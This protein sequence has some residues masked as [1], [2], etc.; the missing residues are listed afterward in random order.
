MTVEDKNKLS[1]REF[2][3]LA[4]AGAAFS[5]AP[6]FLKETPPPNQSSEKEW[7]QLVREKL[8][9]GEVKE[10]LS[11]VPE[12]N[13]DNDGNLESRGIR[14]PFAETQWSK[15]ERTTIEPDAITV[16]WTGD[17]DPEGKY[18]LGVISGYNSVRYRGSVEIVTS[19]HATIGVYPLEHNGPETQDTDYISILQTQRPENGQPTVSSHIR[20]VLVPENQAYDNRKHPINALGRMVELYDLPEDYCY[21]FDFLDNYNYEDANARTISLE[22]LGSNFD[23]EEGHPPAQLIANTVGV[24]LAYMEK[25]PDINFSNITGHHEIQMDKGDPG[26]LFMAELRLV[27]AL[28]ILEG[29]N[30]RLKDN[31]F[32]PFYKEGDTKEETIKRF[33]DFHW[34][35]VVN[36]RWS[37]PKEVYRW[38]KMTNYWNIYQSLFAK[39]AIPVADNFI[40]PVEEHD[41]KRVVLGNGFAIPEAHEG[42]DLNLQETRRIINEDLGENISSIANGRVVFADKVYGVPGLGNTVV[43][44][45]ITGGTKVLS[46]YAHLDEIKVDKGDIVEIGQNIATMGNSGGQMD[47]HLHFA[48]FPAATKRER[49]FNHY[50]QL[51]YQGKEIGPDYE[52][53]TGQIYVVPHTTKE[54]EIFTYYFSPLSFIEE[55]NTGEVLREEDIEKRPQTLRR[56]SGHIPE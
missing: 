42:V 53:E 14:L 34:D 8:P 3:K 50:L 25:Y 6:K 45:H 32:S 4:G 28:K 43:L 56:E 21:L 37:R 44:E 12:I 16:H 11:M 7:P 15:K 35:Y 41:G 33:F 30:E 29:N 26:K 51:K 24:I 54:H 40:L 38:E 49:E 10:V 39:D 22:L 23:S 1:R 46:L 9:G 13:V 52:F 36:S 19:A 2:L 18:V 48:I 31:L 55:R 47:S 17:T 5:M 20:S 27:L